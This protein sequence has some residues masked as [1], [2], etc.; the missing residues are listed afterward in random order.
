MK[1]KNKLPLIGGKDYNEKYLKPYFKEIKKEVIQL[2]KEGYVNK[3]IAEK[4]E[5]NSKIVSKYL[6]KSFT[7]REEIKYVV[8]LNQQ[9]YT[10]KEIVEQLSN[11]L[12]IQPNQKWNDIV[13]GYNVY[14]WL[15]KSGLK[16]FTEKKEDKTNLESKVDE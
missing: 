16:D 4:L 7:E 15:K 9:G 13:T 14:Q 1:R 3:D 10:D 12:W 2:N 6:R 8:E 11:I 5:V